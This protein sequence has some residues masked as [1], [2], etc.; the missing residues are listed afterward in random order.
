MGHLKQIADRQVGADVDFVGMLIENYKQ[1]KENAEK[2]LAFFKANKLIKTDTWMG[3]HSVKHG[4]YLGAEALENAIYFHDNPA[5]WKAAKKR[6][7]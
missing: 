6:T 4:A 7:A 1:T 3:K 2:I 5:E